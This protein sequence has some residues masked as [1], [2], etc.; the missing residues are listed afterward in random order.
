MHHFQRLLGKSTKNNCAI[1]SSKLGGQIN[2][3]AC[4]SM[5]YRTVSC[6]CLQA[7]GET[8]V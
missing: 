1:E 2:L 6:Q 4:Q 5:G 7:V 8:T 3:T